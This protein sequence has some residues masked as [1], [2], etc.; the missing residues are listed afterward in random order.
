MIQSG[1]VHSAQHAPFIAAACLQIARLENAP[2]L[3]GETPWVKHRDRLI[4]K[5][6]YP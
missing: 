3:Y 2:A 1:E 4:A 6:I 5:V